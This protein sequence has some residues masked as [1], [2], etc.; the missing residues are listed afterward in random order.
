MNAEQLQEFEL[1]YGGPQNF[2]KRFVEAVPVDNIEIDAIEDQ[3]R[4][5]GEIPN[6][7]QT[8]KEQIDAHGQIVPITGQRL[9]D[10]KYRCIAGVH[11]Y[12]PKSSPATLCM[13]TKSGKTSERAL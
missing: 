2:K 9:P 3:V 11:R 5:K 13:M 12:L 8:L 4:T 1:S 10:G 6:H 7:I